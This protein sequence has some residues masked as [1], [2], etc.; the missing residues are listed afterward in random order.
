MEATNY[1]NMKRCLN[2]W[3]TNESDLKRCS[4]CGFLFL[5]EASIEEKEKKIEEIEKLKEKSKEKE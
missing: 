2:C 1:I 5:E 3:H 4:S